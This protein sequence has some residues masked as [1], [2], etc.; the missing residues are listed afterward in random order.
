MS[1]TDKDAPS[2]VRAR[3]DGGDT[4]HHRVGD[5]PG[6]ADGFGRPPSGDGTHACDLDDPGGRCTWRVP[7]WLAGYPLCQPPDTSC[8]HMFYYGPDRAQARDAL[9]AAA[10]EY[11]TFGMTETEPITRQVRHSPWG[12]GWWD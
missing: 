10:R 8:L 6:A 9:R 7:H 11:N 1:R 12:G 5:A 3:R 4:W 2:W